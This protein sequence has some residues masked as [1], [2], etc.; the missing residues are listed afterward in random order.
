MKEYIDLVKNV[1]DLGKLKDNR[2]KVPAISHFGDQIFFDLRKGFPILTTKKINFRA[3]IVELLWFISGKT[4]IRYLL[5]RNVKIWTL[6]PFEKFKKSDDFKGETIKEFEQKILEDRKFSK[7]WGDC[8]PIY[9]HQWRNF[10]GVDQLFNIIFSIR[11]IPIS[12][13]L[14]ISAWNLA[15]I[16]E[17][18]LPPCHM[19]CQ[20]YVEDDKYLNCKMYQRSGDLFIGVPFNISSYA[21]LLSLIAKQT[22]LIPKLLIISYGDLHIYKNHLTQIYKQIKRKSYKLPK[23]KINKNVDSIFKYKIS[24]IKLVD[25]KCHPAIKGDIAV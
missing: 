15:D 7:K 21:L 22:G 20:F 11:N 9:G 13:R 23:L 19:M 16:S 10:G 4:N 5:K 25:Y 6:W 8:G 3:I 12:R 1:L 24:D 18:I 2:T 17:M 14:I